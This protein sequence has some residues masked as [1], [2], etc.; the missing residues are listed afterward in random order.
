VK[1]LNIRPVQNQPGDDPA[2][3]IG[4]IEFEMAQQDVEAMVVE[5]DKLP[6]PAREVTRPWRTKVLARH[7]ALDAAQRIATASLAQLGEPHVRGPS[8]R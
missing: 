1:L 4:R 2:T 3:V 7:D 5:L 6:A 8:P